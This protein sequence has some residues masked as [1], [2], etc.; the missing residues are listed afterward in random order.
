MREATNEHS[1]FL[2]NLARTVQESADSFAGQPVVVFI[3]LLL[4]R[5]VVFTATDRRLPAV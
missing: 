4:H 3:V 5:Q 2:S 1:P